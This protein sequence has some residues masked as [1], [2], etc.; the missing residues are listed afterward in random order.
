MNI[1]RPW[2][3]IGIGVT[4][5]LLFLIGGVITA[6]HATTTFDWVKAYCALISLGSCVGTVQSG[7][8]RLQKAPSTTKI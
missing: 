1:L 4:G 5:G 7:Y 2:I 6:A 3:Q 8:K